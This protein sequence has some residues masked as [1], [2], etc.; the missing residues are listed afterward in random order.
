[1]KFIPLE[2]LCFYLNK[3]IPNNYTQIRA[4]QKYS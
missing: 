4:M 3:I 1:M 2:F